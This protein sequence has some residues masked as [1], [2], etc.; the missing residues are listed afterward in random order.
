[1]VSFQHPHLPVRLF[2]SRE[3]RQAVEILKAQ[4]HKI[5]FHHEVDA[6]G[7]PVKNPQ[8]PSPAWLD[9]LFG[10]NLMDRPFSFEQSLV[11]NSRDPAPIAIQRLTRLFSLR[12]LKVS[13]LDDLSCIKNLTRLEELDLRKQKGRCPLNTSNCWNNSISVTGI[14]KMKK[15]AC[16]PSRNVAD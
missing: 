16:Q 1:M 12:E 8:S 7:Q 2:D 10:P 11:P 13:H 14:P 9:R 4:G 6:Q 15:P 3:T 5:V